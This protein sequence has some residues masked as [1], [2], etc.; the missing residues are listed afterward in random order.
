MLWEKAAVVAVMGNSGAL[1]PSRG[2]PH[3]MLDL[4]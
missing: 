4:A 1:A 2:T 3:L